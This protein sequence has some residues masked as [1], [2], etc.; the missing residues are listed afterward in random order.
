MKKQLTEKIV[1]QPNEDV[2]VT[3][4]NKPTYDEDTGRNSYKRKVTIT[5]DLGWKPEKLQFADTNAIEEFVN[6]INFEDPQS[7]LDLGQ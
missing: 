5:V 2:K 6:D 7:E 1:Y 4:E 3:V